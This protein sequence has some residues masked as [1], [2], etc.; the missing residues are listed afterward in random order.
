[1]SV[2]PAMGEAS[3][4][5]QI[6]DTDA[7]RALFAKPHRGF[8]HDSGVGLELVFFGIAHGRPIRCLGSYNIGN[9]RQKLHLFARRAAATDKD[10]ERRGPES[11]T[12]RRFDRE[13]PSKPMTPRRDLPCTCSI[14]I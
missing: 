6:G 10:G 5:H 4:L 1:M 12:S 8:L 2:E 14:P 9:R 13:Y 3:V 11:L 7:M